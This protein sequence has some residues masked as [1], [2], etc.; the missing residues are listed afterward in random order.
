MLKITGSRSSYRG[1]GY[2]ED[3]D[4]AAVGHLPDARPQRVG[5]ARHLEHDVESLGHP[6]LALGVA[7]V[8]LARVDGE[9]RAHPPGGSS[10]FGSRSVTTT[11]RAPAWR[12]TATDMQPIG[13][14][15]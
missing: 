3:R 8:A 12:A 14:R 13:P 4:A 6:E 9:R 15:R 10:R 11:W 7:E 5:V 2:P 1:G